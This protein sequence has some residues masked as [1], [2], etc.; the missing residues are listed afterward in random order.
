M[1]GSTAVGVLALLVAVAVFLLAGLF[2]L[3][4]ERKGPPNGSDRGR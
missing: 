1:T 4:D 2:Y 3:G